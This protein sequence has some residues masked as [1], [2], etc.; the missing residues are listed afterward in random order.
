M[1]LN[2]YEILRDFRAAETLEDKKQVLRKNA[3]PCLK[4]VLRAVFHPN[5]QFTVTE[6]PLYKPSIMPPGM[7]QSIMAMEINK[8]YLFER[9]NPRVSPNLT[10]ERK[11]VILIQILESLEAEEAKVFSGIL[12]KNLAVPELS[13]EMVNEVFPGIFD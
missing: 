12:K 10:D 6:V 2:I 11:R 13:Y 9:G 8:L 3:S 1:Y 4:K 5:I 7:G